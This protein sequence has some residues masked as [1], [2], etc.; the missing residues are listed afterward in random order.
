MPKS[1]KSAT[2]KQESP[3]PETIQNDTVETAPAPLKKTRARKTAQPTPEADAPTQTAGKK[4]S[5][6]RRTF[7]IL[8]VT[9]DGQRET[10]EG[11]HYYKSKTPG[12]A[13]RK[14]ATKACKMLYGDEPKCTI[15]I[16][17]K[18]VTKNSSTQKPKEYPYRA[19][20]TLN[21]K[22]VPFKGQSGKVDI[23]FK[24]HMDLKS[25]RKDASGKVV[26]ENDVPVDADAET[27]NEP[28]V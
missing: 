24:F 9:R 2:Q 27:V 18:E 22:D 14:G 28:V 21:N 26:A 3:A 13:A 17:I 15:D 16:V 11:D 5:A 8:S 10:L 19:T 23:F 25:L 20:R 7:T 12:G 4:D 1:T 6:A